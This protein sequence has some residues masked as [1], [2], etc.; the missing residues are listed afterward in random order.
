MVQAATRAPE[1]DYVFGLDLIRFAAASMVALFHLTR[2]AP[3][4]PVAPYG[5]VGVQI[6]FVLSGFVITA[7]ARGRSTRAFVRARA[8][9]LYPAAWCCGALSLLALVS[10]PGAMVGPAGLKTAHAVGLKQLFGAIALVLPWSPA[11]SYWTL[12]LELAFYAIVAALLRWSEFRHLEK[13]AFALIAW[14][15]PYI[16][17][18]LAQLLG[19]PQAPSI[20]QGFGLS[21]ALLFRYGFYFGSGILLSLSLQS[22]FH[23]SRCL[24]LTA[25]AALA[26]CEIMARAEWMTEGY[27]VHLDVTA[28]GLEA[29]CIFLVAVTAIVLC[30]RFNAHVPASPRLRACV[31]AM[32]LM[33]YP[34]YLLHERVGGST[35]LLMSAQGVPYSLALVAG[36]ALAAALSIVIVRGPEPWLRARLVGASPPPGR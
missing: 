19:L 23:G 9:R 1:G 2:Q 35:A 17:L 3:I 16:I 6:F 20:G 11:D 25:A 28:L 36:L 32:G 31:R 4:A 8:G 21:N 12:P 5:W 34:L 15:L 10:L 27:S 26:L 33:T 14:S 18:L 7:S 22:G 29:F 13:V 30:T 24:A